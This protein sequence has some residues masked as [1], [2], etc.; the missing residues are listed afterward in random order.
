M[1]DK[2]RVLDS[3][4][5]TDDAKVRK[6]K[7]KGNFLYNNKE[8]FVMIKC[9]NSY[10]LKSNVFNGKAF[11]R[12]FTVSDVGFIKRIKNYVLKNEIALKF[13]DTNY[14]ASGIQYIKVNHYKAGT[15]LNDLCYIDID[16]A[17][18]TTAYMLG[19]ISKSI[20]TDGLDVKKPVRLAALGSLAKVKE[21]WAYD[22]D[23]FEKKPSIRSVET[24]NIWFAI[25]K[26]V[27]DVMNEV[28]RELKE[29][30]VFYW[31]DGIY[32]SN[33]PKVVQ[34]VIS[35][36]QKHGYF[37]KSE[38]IPEIRFF[39]DGFEVQGVIKDSV[40][41][42]SYNMSGTGSKTV[43]DMIEDNKLKKLAKE[44]MYKKSRKN[45]NKV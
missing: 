37:S 14:K 2:K 24:E 42:F 44:I 10:E 43:A 6:L 1:E 4:D 11:K 29:D 19:V 35:I 8:P 7:M 41:R 31:V 32:V 45:E 38:L 34:K 22:G 39:Q 13:I 12:G 20:Y 27:S 9:G 16:S 23:K 17:Y 3:A 40:K 36:F 30:F 33:K 28:A 5:I 21:V 18:W 26:K 25:C 15:I